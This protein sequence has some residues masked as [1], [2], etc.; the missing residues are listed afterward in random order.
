[1]RGYS[2]KVKALFKMLFAIAVLITAQTVCAMEEEK[3]FAVGKAKQ[4]KEIVVGKTTINSAAFSRG[5]E[6]EILLNLSDVSD[7][8]R[9]YDIQ[10]GNIVKKELGDKGK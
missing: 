8:Y 6:N 7:E 10:S 3:I 2:M 5:N 9:V 1:M 4:I